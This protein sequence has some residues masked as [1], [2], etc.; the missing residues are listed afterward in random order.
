M[1]DTMYCMIGQ[2]DESTKNLNKCMLVCPTK[3]LGPSFKQIKTQVSKSMISWINYEMKGHS[4]E[5]MKT[6][7]KSAKI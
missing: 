6:F 3:V 4:C 1:G 2:L 5:T 7:I